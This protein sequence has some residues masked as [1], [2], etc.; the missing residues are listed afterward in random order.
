MKQG[1]LVREFPAPEGLRVEIVGSSSDVS[2][3]AHPERKVRVEIAYEVHGWGKVAAELERAFLENPPVKLTN[4]LLRIGPAPDGVSADYDLW[5]PNEAEVE[6]H[7]GSGDIMASGLS[8]KLLARAGSGDVILREVSGEVHIRCGSGDI[9]LTKTFGAIFVRTGSGDIRGKEIKGF[10]DLETGSGDVDL[11]GVEGELRLV[12]GSGDVWI[13]GELK[14]ETWRVLTSSG[15]VHLKL[16]QDIEAEIS[17]HTDL[18]EIDCDFTLSPGEVR[19]GRVVG[20]L[21]SSPKARLFV[22]TN[23]GDIFVAKR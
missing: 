5:L 23:T 18:G 4:G 9:A 3:H 12:T 6:V 10:I 13:E 22:E 2:L 19:E 1:N 16:P 11:Q 14:E 7:L 15:D 21:G 8:R 17:L 20:K